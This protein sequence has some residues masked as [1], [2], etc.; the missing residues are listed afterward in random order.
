MDLTIVVKNALR[1]VLDAGDG[2]MRR[3]NRVG[4]DEQIEMAVDSFLGLFLRTVLFAEET[5]PLGD[6]LLIDAGTC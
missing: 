2:E 4:I 6:C 3:E 1:L 5:R